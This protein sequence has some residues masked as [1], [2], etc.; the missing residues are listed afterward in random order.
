M[1]LQA[2]TRTYDDVD[3]PLT[4]RGFL[5]TDARI[6]AVSVLGESM[7]NPQAAPEQGRRFGIAVVGL[8]NYAQYVLAR[9]HHRHG[10]AHAGRGRGA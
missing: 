1:R 7:G 10:A 9:V 4:R 3:V 2:M 6:A 8:G 5:D